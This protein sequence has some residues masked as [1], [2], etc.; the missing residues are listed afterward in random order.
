MAMPELIDATLAAYDAMRL[1][2]T[3][4]RGVTVSPCSSSGPKSVATTRGP[5]CS[6]DPAGRKD[7]D[8]RTKPL[9]GSARSVPLYE[10]RTSVWDTTP[11]T[12]STSDRP[13]S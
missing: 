13:M 9:A 3:L 5:S 1:A 11:D 2:V 10:K 6:G 7:G 12:Q 8:R 4:S